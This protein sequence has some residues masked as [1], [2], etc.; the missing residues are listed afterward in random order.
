[1]IIG[2]SGFYEALKSKG[3]RLLD[4]AVIHITGG[5]YEALKSKGLRLA[6]VGVIGHFW[7]RFYEALKS[8]G[9][10]LRRPDSALQKFQHVFMK[11]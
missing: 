10:R 2:K 4:L 6:A 11:P 3:L 5:F 9:L 8:K 1:M 7:L